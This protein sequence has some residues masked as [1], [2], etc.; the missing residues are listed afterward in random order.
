MGP[1]LWVSNSK[2]HGTIFM[3]FKFKNSWDQFYGFKFQP[4]G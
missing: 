4:G 3:G 1:F 2:I